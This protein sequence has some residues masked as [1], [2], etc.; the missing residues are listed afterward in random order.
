M[1]KL[2]EKIN[3]ALSS[4]APITVI[5]FVLS[6]TITPLPLQTMLMFLAGALLLI[7]GMGFFSLGAEMSMMPMGEGVGRQLAK[8][9]KLWVMVLITF[10]IGIIITVAEPDLAVLAHQVPAVSDQTLIWTV[11]G[12]VG[13]FLVLAMLR[14]VCKLKLHHLLLIFYGIVFLLSYLT[15]DSFLAVAFDSGG[16]TTGPI[17]VPF[18]MA[19]GIGIA[20]FSDDSHAQEDSFGLVALCSIGPILAVLI[21]G[22]LYHPDSVSYSPFEMVQA[23]TTQ[24]IFHVFLAEIPHTMLEVGIALGPVM[25]FFL[26]FQLLTRCYFKKQLIKILIGALYTYLGLVLF[27]CGVNVGFMPAGS[28]LG[29]KIVSLSYRGILI[30]IGMIIGYFIVKAEPAVHVLKVQVEEISAGTITGKALEYSLSIGVAISL[31]IAMLRILTGINIM[32]F[33]IPGYTFALLLS[34]IVPEIFTAIAFDSGGVAS[35]PMTATF[36]LPFAMG[37]CEAIGGNVLTDAFGIVAMVAMTPLITIQIMGLI[38][39]RKHHPLQLDLNGEDHILD[40][41]EEPINE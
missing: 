2:K 4:V 29:A 32:F 37:A 41:E 10:A 28:Y 12:G 36:L 25:L 20:Q 22:I 6:I 31:G 38:S 34:F 7:I 40:F 15:P 39:I 24:D 35:G 18:I 26:L 21:L 11:A 16:V 30:P 8:S 33:L 23:E 13:I 9:R 19:L 14:T 1:K 5:V 3:E 17:T 27:L